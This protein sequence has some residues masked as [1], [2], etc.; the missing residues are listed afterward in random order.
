M[1]ALANHLVV[2]PIVLPL[3]AAALTLLIN[4]RQRDLR[5]AVSFAATVALAA[6]D[7]IDPR[8]AAI[9][10][11]G[12]FAR[13]RG[14]GGW[15]KRLTK[16]DRTIIFGQVHRW[17]ICDLHVGPRTRLRLGRANRER[18]RQQA[19]DGAQD[20]DAKC[21]FHRHFTCE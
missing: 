13:G 2:I 15:A 10:A 3:A 14:T 4:E 20:Q 1:I 19:A 11:G 8:A 5:V 18:R 6:V 12:G 9:A 21:G 7:T 16:L 17:K